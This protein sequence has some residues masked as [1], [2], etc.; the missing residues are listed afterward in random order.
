MNAKIN[1]NKLLNKQRTF[2][3]KNWLLS[4]LGSYVGTIIRLDGTNRGTM[5]QSLL[6]ESTLVV[7]HF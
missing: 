5:D 7:C 1:K 4:Y 3:V 2:L 6:W